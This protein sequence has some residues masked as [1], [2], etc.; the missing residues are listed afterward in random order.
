M[1]AIA[2]ESRLSR[3]RGF[4]CMLSMLRPRL[5]IA[6]R[7][8]LLLLVHPLLAADDS[9]NADA[10]FGPPVFSTLR[11]SPS[12]D[13]FVSIVDV[14]GLNTALVMVD[15][16]TG[17][18]ETLVRQRKLSVNNVW[19]VGE[20]WLLTLLDFDRE[21]RFFRVINLETMESTELTCMDLYP[22]RRILHFL[23]AEEDVVIFQLQQANSRDLDLAKVN[24]RTNSLEVFAKDPGGVA[25][26]FL[27]S[28]GQV[29]AGWGADRSRYFYATPSAAGRGFERTF[30]EKFEQ[31]SL[32]PLGVAP[33]DRRLVAVDRSD[34]SRDQVVY[35]AP[36]AREVELVDQGGAF[37]LHRV[38]TWGRHDSRVA[39]VVWA[40]TGGRLVLPG[41]G[42]E[43][44]WTW[45]E[46][47][48]RGNQIELQSFSADGRLA[49]AFVSSG[50][51][52]GGFVRIDFSDRKIR[53]LGTIKPALRSVSFAQPQ[54][55]LIPTRS[56]QQMLAEIWLPTQVERPPLILWVGSSLSPA[57]P[58]AGWN[59][60][61]QYFASQGYAVAR[62]HHRGG[63]GRGRAYQASGDFELVTGLVDDLEDG[64]VW[65]LQNEA[66]DPERVAVLGEYWAG[67]AGATLIGQRGRGHAFVGW[68]VPVKS[69]YLKPVDLASSGLSE[70]IL[71]ELS[72]GWSRVRAAMKAVDPEA[73]L[74]A[75]AVP[76]LYYDPFDAN[77]LKRELEKLGRDVEFVY[78]PS[79]HTIKEDEIPNWHLTRDR[80]VETVRF[81]KDKL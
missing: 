1:G 78:D 27:D 70:E 52:P 42:V 4:A 40:G 62:L 37:G 50:R 22:V 2:D 71:V 7:V 44:Q 47:A 79:R 35:W 80:A 66:V 5:P 16:G 21:R 39:S 53:S 31:P 54:I 29:V 74:K 81:L 19:W 34:P 73:L 6:L 75:M 9:V 72:G 41:T 58:D 14:D 38:E 26:W 10:Y 32:V 11:L 64:L 8:G 12:A 24:L 15:L 63:S 3:S 69:A 76:A 61:A 48:L 20:N 59:S 68:D 60:T 23:P 28:Q 65:L 49:V 51:N 18:Q 45:L 56:Q 77:A 67:L 25:E 13:R 46:Q 43:D 33:D 57:A 30:L 17:E 55:R 36:P